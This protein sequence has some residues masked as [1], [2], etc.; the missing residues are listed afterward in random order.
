[1]VSIAEGLYYKIEIITIIGQQHEETITN[2]SYFNTIENFLKLSIFFIIPG[3][4]IFIQSILTKYFIKRHIKR[5]LIKWGELVSVSWLMFI[6]LLI[7]F[8]II[9]FHILYKL[10]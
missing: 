6:L 3:L 10:S 1:M 8:L 2:E 7:G 4:G 9:N 5:E